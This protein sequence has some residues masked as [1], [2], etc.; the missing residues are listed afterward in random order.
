MGHLVYVGHLNHIMCKLI[1]KYD[2]QRN[3]QV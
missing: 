2:D 1:I 3:N